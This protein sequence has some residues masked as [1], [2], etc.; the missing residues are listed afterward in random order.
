MFDNYSAQAPGGPPSPAVEDMFANL[1]KPLAGRIPPPVMVP[2]P[3]RPQPAI[4]SSPGTTKYL[5]IGLVTLV[6]ILLSL[7]AVY[8]FVLAP[9]FQTAVQSVQP[10][11]PVVSGNP[12]IAAADTPTMAATAAP[13]STLDLSATP[14]N[15]VTALVATTTAT[16][17]PAV[18]TDTVPTATTSIDS[19]HDGLTDAEEA[20]IGTDP[21]NTDTDGDGLSDY[22]EVRIWHTNPLVADTD[23][24]GYPDG[25]EVKNSYNPNGPGKLMIK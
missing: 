3:S 16:N 11:T 5:I 7:L 22:D 13:S 12:V 6:V 1:D 2:R 18:A 8:K 21:N 24:D 23:S 25:E 15:Q 14:D 4:T 17:S 20:V 10:S 19:D 9:K